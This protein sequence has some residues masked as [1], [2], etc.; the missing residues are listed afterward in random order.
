MLRSQ[1]Q[2]RTLLPTWSSGKA[3]LFVSELTKQARGC[4]GSLAARERLAEEPGPHQVGEADF[5]KALASSKL[6]RAKAG[7]LGLHLEAAG[8]TFWNRRVKGKPSRGQKERR[9]LANLAQ[10][11][12]AKD[13]SGLCGPENI[14]RKLPGSGGGRREIL[15]N[16]LPGGIMPEA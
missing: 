7:P 15:G 14:N 16:S 8:F 3:Q 5:Q 9:T 11:W 10:A 1:G 13:A 6:I 12:T 2:G 4:V